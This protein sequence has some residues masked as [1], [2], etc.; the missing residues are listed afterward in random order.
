M[1]DVV[2]KETA[3]STREKKGKMYRAVKKGETRAGLGCF[4]D[5][6]RQ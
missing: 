3:Q 4:T 6:G 2:L 5:L 1:G